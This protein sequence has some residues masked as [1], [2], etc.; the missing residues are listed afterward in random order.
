MRRKISSVFFL[1]SFLLAMVGRPAL[2]QTTLPW[3]QAEP[4]LVESPLTNQMHA[5]WSDGVRVRHSVEESS[6]VWS[7]PSSIGTGEVRPQGVQFGPDGSLHVGYAGEFSQNWEGFYV[8]LIP[9]Q[10]WTLP[11]NISHTSG[12]SREV[13]IHVGPDGNVFTAWADNT[14]GYSVI[15]SGEECLLLER[16]PDYFCGRPLQNSRDGREP[17][18]AVFQEGTVVVWH[19]ASKIFFHWP[20]SPYA[21]EIA[22]TTSPASNLCMAERF[23]GGVMI[24]WRE[25][26]THYLREAG[27]NE[28]QFNM[29]QLLSPRVFIPLIQ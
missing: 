18:I 28:G 3:G 9:G 27:V 13:A 17:D 7:S 20:G 16:V 19:T 12:E 8:K 29:G 11:R 15:Y 5:I 24:F 22:S 6:G 23:Y 4:I 10:A 1:A 21:Y 26:E 14:P 2:A 25:A